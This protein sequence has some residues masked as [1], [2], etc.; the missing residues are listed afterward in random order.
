MGR[1][2]FATTVESSFTVR[3]ILGPFEPTIDPIPDTSATVTVTVT[4]TVTGL[5]P[6]LPG[7]D[8]AREREMTY[9]Q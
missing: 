1:G 7:Q 3:D 2:T 5:Q 9:Q 8:R 6:Y 4:G